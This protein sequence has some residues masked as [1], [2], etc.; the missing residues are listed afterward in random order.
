MN[1]T[2]PPPPPPP[3]KSVMSM[4]RDHIHYHEQNP[5]LSIEKR[6]AYAI[7]VATIK[8]TTVI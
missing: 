8:Y 3:Q 7:G 2:N 6:V 5:A 4:S 1:K